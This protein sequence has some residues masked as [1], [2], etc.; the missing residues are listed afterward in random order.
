MDECRG[1][2]NARDDLKI[3]NKQYTGI[4]KLQH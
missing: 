1:T 2:V 4:N 3:G